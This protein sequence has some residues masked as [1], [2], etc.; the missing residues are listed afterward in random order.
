MYTH[1]INIILGNFILKIVNF[2][3]NIVNFIL[4]ILKRFEK[5]K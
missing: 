2:I 1:Y 5:L 4:N 3:L